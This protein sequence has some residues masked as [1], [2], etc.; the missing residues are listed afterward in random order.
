MSLNYWPWAK[1]SKEVNKIRSKVITQ[2]V[3]FPTKIFKKKF[4]FIVW[5]RSIILV[6]ADPYCYLATSFCHGQV[7]RL[8]SRCSGQL[9]PRLFPF[10]EYVEENMLGSLKTPVPW[11]TTDMKMHF[12][13]KEYS[14]LVQTRYYP[15]RTRYC[16]SAP[17]SNRMTSHSGRLWERWPQLFHTEQSDRSQFYS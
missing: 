4:P 12:I 11:T 6:A 15:V 7:T 9:N 14:Y 5:G 16:T 10:C 2:L 17:L 1:H 3:H 8:V 13:F